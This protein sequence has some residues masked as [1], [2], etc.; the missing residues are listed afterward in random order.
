MSKMTF[1]NKLE[2]SRQS[3]TLMYERDY[4]NNP[5]FSGY[6]YKEVE[7]DISQ[8]ISDLHSFDRGKVYDVV[9]YSWEEGEDASLEDLNF[10]MSRE[11][12]PITQKEFDSIIDTIIIEGITENEYF[13]LQREY[14]RTYSL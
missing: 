9:T 1:T 12:N 2:L 11:D 3:L 7:E 4:Q 8:K 13:R 10:T 5:K 14:Y 6:E